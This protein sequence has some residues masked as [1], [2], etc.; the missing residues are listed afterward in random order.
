MQKILPCLWYDNQADE[1]ARFYTSIFENSKI[2]GTS[3]NNNEG[4]GQKGSVLTITFQLNGQEMMALNGGP[5]HKFTPAMSLFVNCENQEEVDYYWEKLVEGGEKG[6][7][8]WLTDK[9]G[10]SWQIVPTILD[11]LLS[12]KDANKA[13]SVMR[14]MLQMK[15]L[16]IDKLKQAYNQG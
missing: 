6:Q 2:E 9:F 8:G 10:V 11:V 13:A 5:A 16:D 3:Y 4:P 7:C 12:D 15:K 14:V 1:A